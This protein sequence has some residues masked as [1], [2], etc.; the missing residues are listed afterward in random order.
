VDALPE[1]EALVAHEGRAPGSDAERRA[2]KHLEA[3]LHDMGRDARL[4]PIEV[5]PS[6][7]L[8]HL[9][10][11]LAAVVGSVLSVSAPLPA[12][13]VLL[14]TAVSAFGDLTGSFHLARRLTPRRASQNV[15][16]REDGDRAG[17][18]VLVAHYDAARAGAVFGWRFADRAFAAF[19]WSIVVVLACSALRLAGLDATPLTVVQFLA[20]AALIVS[21]PL[22]ADIALSGVVP[23]A[24]D[25]ASGVATVLRLA[26][27]YGGDLDHF[28]VWVVL[29]GA[30]EGMELGMRA[31][32][33]AQRR[34]LP[35]GRTAVV[36][37]DQVGAGTVRYARREGYLLPNAHNPALVELCDQ[38]ADED[39]GED[40]RYG[41]RSYTARGATDAYAA[42]SAGLPAVSV[43]CLGARDVAPHHHR[44]SDTVENVDPDALER[45]FRF[46]SEL[47]ELIDERIGPDLER[48]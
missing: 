48:E 6:F 43:S 29:T 38:I 41:A 20:T 8:T 46:C 45:A 3:R 4:E 24:N 25:N 16:S 10:H 9:L 30:G 21:I 17:T 1:I 31:W 19:F 36:C 37:V 42:R 13:A 11:A 2:A 5:R 27:R 15:V 47:I 40:G 39:S 44:P 12:T 18:L 28:D 34:R 14:V 26:E 35:R 22:F 7:T 33:R 32:L 23:G